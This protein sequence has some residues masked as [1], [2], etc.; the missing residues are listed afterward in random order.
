MLD[1]EI[2][3]TSASDLARLMALDHS[4]RSDSVW[5]LELRRDAGQF[6]ATFREVR[7]PRPI[8]LTYPRDPFAL[9]DEWKRRAPMLTALAGAEPIGYISGLEQ[10]SGSL[11]RITDM[12]VGSQSRRQGVGNG[13]LDAAEQWAAKRG[14]RRIMI[15][16][17]SKNLPAIRLAQKRGYEFC[18]YNDHYYLSQDVA[19]FFVRALK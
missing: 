2:H 10:P 3:P 8:M 5:Q 7:L 13:M 4:V 19:L 11:V 15:E 14:I 16:L 18:G 17:P 12:V 6:V 9:A 1:I